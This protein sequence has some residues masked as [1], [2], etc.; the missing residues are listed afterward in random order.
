MRL[1]AAR[2]EELK[3]KEVSYRL[4]SSEL[5]LDTGTFTSEHEAWRRRQDSDD[6]DDPELVAT[7]TKGTNGRK[8]MMRTSVSINS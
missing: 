3:R 7:I 5:H 8:K 1:S 2:R 6:E 4:V